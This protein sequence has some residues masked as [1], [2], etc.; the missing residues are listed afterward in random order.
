MIFD[1]LKTVILDKSF[2]KLLGRKINNKD[3]EMKMS[4]RTIKPG[5]IAGRLKAPPSKS[6]MLRAVAAAFLA[7]EKSLILNPSFC[8]DARAG[9][10]IL[11]SLGAVVEEKNNMVVI[12]SSRPADNITLNC[13]ESGLC[14]RMFAPIA[15]LYKQ[16]IVLTGTG[17]L[18]KRPMKMME[19]PLKKLRVLFLCDHGYLPVKIKGP[20]MGGKIRI[21]AS[22]SSQFL[23]GLLMALPHCRQDSLIIADDLHSKPYVLMT[24][25]MLSFCGIH[26]DTDSNLSKFHIAGS[27]SCSKFVC[28]IE[29][30]WSGAA[31]LLVG[32]ALAGSITV[33]DLQMDSYQAD[34]KILDVLM[35]CGA[36]VIIEGN[37]VTVNKASL[38]AFTFD[39]EDCP[40]LFPPLAVLACYCRGLSVIS[41][42]SRLRYKESSRAEVLTKELTRL[43]AEIKISGDKMKIQGSRLTGGILDAHGDHRIAMA[44]AISALNAEKSVKINGW[45]CVSKSYPSFFED[46][47]EVGGKIR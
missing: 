30:D 10:G 1:P 36:E 13:R 27:Q 28:R 14:A 6:M 8:D 33:K 44:G 42:V 45:E 32:G 12:R 21:D 40:D 18:L 19:S 11:E 46:L 7:E 47:K 15:A 37:T 3:K 20:M 22:L 29:G 34:K 38:D 41:G 2:E 5:K 23:S 39:A 17:S 35:K 9:L 4:S 24:I 26:I 25:A 16:E 43:G 31:F